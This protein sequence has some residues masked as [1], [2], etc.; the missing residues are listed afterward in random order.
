MAQTGLVVGH[1]HS[2]DP[3]PCNAAIASID[4]IL[5]EALTDVA[6]RIGAYWRGHLERLAQRH[7]IVGDVRGR[8]LLQGVELVRDR[9]TR[10]PAPLAGQQVGRLCLENGLIF[11]LR[12]G[13]SVLRFVPPFT[14][15]EAQ[16]DLAAEILDHAIGAVI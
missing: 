9:E 6:K 7:E 16:L 3:L 1:S 11:S 10:E 2:N 12:R 8:G 13:G 5:E 14:T 15:T 4:V